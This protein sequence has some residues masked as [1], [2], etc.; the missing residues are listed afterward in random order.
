MDQRL[1]S[2]NVKSND[3]SNVIEISKKQYIDFVRCD[4]NIKIKN[5]LKI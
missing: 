5:N 3:Y 4:L 1:H 2:A